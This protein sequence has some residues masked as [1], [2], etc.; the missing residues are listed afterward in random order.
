MNKL[1]DIWWVRV[2]KENKEILSK[3]R[4]AEVS[5]PGIVGKVFHNWNNKIEKGHN[6]LKLTFDSG[7]N[8]YDFGNEIT[9]EQFLHFELGQN[10][11]YELW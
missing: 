8:G 3:W 11:N 1:P 4:T 2:T 10:K 6:S 5:E 9:F 7:L